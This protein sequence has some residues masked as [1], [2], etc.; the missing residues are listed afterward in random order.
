MTGKE[1]PGTLERGVE[2]ASQ[3]AIGDSGV[4]TNDM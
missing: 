4:M 1:T 3:S 2:I